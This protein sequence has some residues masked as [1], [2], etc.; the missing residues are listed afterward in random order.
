MQLL[1][2]KE[3]NKWLDNRPL[4]RDFI[5]KFPLNDVQAYSGYKHGYTNYCLPFKELYNASYGIGIVECLA[6]PDGSLLKNCITPL[7]E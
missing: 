2:D 7:M 1:I 3:M 6:D 5:E 4:P